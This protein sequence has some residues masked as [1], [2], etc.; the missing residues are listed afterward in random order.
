MDGERSEMELFSKS[1][2]FSSHI[3]LVKSPQRWRS[4]SNLWSGPITFV[5]A[6]FS[7]AFYWRE[8]KHICF[9]VKI[10]V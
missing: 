2:R 1:F 8:E 3:L 4:E 7:K 5:P 10:N 6:R 9:G